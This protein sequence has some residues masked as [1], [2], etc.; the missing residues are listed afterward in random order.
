MQETVAAGKNLVGGV[1]QTE[2]V[3]LQP[4]RRREGA[5]LDQCHALERIDDVAD[6]LGVRCEAARLLD[7]GIDVALHLV[8]LDHLIMRAAMEEPIAVVPQQRRMHLGDEPLRRGERVLWI[9]RIA[10]TV[11]TTCGQRLLQP[12]DLDLEVVPCG[13]AH[14]LPAHHELLEGCPV[15]SF[16][17]HQ[18]GEMGRVGSS[19]VSSSSRIASSLATAASICGS[20]IFTSITEEFR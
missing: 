20:L 4:A 17:R 12:T 13:K 1:V 19:S 10:T 6:A 5:T 9:E 16:H 14:L 18:H 15:R 8:G 7:E 2:L 3:L 11:A